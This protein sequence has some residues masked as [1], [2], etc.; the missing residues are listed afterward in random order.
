MHTSVSK[1]IL[2]TSEGTLIFG[3]FADNGLPIFYL[4]KTPNEFDFTQA[5]LGFYWCYGLNLYERF[6]T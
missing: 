4:Q 6:F 3:G 1:P 2:E 5:F